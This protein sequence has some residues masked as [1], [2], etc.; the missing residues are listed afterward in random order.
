MFDISFKNKN[1]DVLEFYPNNLD[2]T[3]TEFQGLN[4]PDATI[5]TSEIALFDGTKFNSSK[6]N[7]RTI[8]VTFVIE[9]RAEENR[10]QVYKVLKSK[11]WIEL[12]Y[13]GDYRNVR[14]EG[15]IESIGI[16]YF[17]MKQNVTVTILCPSPFFKD[18]QSIIN[19][20]DNTISLFH[21]PFS[22]LENEPIPISYLDTLTSVTIENKGDVSCGCIIEI[23][24][25]GT[26][27]NPRILNYVTGEYFAL[28]FT[29]EMGDSIF[30]NSNAGV[31][32]VELLREGQYTNIFNYIAQG[33]KWIQLEYG[34][35]TFVYEAD[36]VTIANMALTFTH[37]N[38]YEGV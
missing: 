28:D 25:R 17:N 36:D 34:E 26:V 29:M 10:L 19:D 2:L 8:D 14:I 1:G 15:Y 7:A 24:A 9:R 6:V 37:E 4:P 3:I 12:I 16:D 22:I 31:K 30:I 23:Y 35:N 33:S 11:Q 5:N 38:L 27:M 13:K 20:I 32:S 21:F 18:A